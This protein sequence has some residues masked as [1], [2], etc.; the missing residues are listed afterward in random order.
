MLFI[1]RKSRF[2]S[3]KLTLRVDVDCLHIYTLKI[4]GF[5]FQ[6]TIYYTDMLS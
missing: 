4:Q 2:H 3:L 5:D 6:G 1:C